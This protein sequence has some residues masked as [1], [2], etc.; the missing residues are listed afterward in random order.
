MNQSGANSYVAGEA[1]LELGY[2]FI[3]FSWRRSEKAENFDVRNVA[4]AIGK[5]SRVVD[6][7]PP[8]VTGY[9]VETPGSNVIRFMTLIECD[10][11]LILVT[12]ETMTNSAPILHRALITSFR[13]EPTDGA[14][15]GL[16]PKFVSLEVPPTWSMELSP[17]Q[18]VPT[19]VFA[20]I[21]ERSSILLETT[22]SLAAAKGPDLRKRFDEQ[23][24]GAAGTE[25]QATPVERV[26]EPDLSADLRFTAVMRGVPVV[27]YVIGLQCEALQAAV[28]IMAISVD[29]KKADDLYARARRARCL[30]PS[31]LRGH[32]TPT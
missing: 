19:T 14:M 25:V 18:R 20:S 11:R 6:L 30:S 8:G 13:C 27:G 29:A 9:T 2:H 28:F 17:P 5:D 1:G 24:K 16:D 26:G 31:E 23:M 4:A 15:T 7:A 3:R 21:T 12:S 32:V 22:P 10:R